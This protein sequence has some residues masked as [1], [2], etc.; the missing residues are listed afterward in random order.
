[1]ASPTERLP[2]IRTRVSAS[3]PPWQVTGLSEA[4]LPERAVLNQEI[5]VIL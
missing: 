3:S 4:G 1:M 2:K 5:E